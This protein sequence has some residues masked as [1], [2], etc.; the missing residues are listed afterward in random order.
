MAQHP[1]LVPQKLGHGTVG[2]P[3]NLV[4]NFYKLNISDVEI[5]HYDVEITK[6]QV[7]PQP[8]KPAFVKSVPPPSP[9]N[10]DSTGSSEKTPTAEKFIRL[11][12]PLIL[13]KVLD[14]KKDMF[15][16][17]AFVFDGYKSLYTTR[18]LVLDAVLS[19]KPGYKV[20]ITIDGR[21]KDFSFR[22]R[23]VERVAVRE[24][25]DYYA[26]KGN[27]VGERTLSAYEVA[28][29][30]I[31]GLNYENFRRSHYDIDTAEKSPK[32]RD[33]EYVFGFNSGV[34]MTE[35]GLAL[36]MHLKTSC[37]VNRQYTR[38]LD[39][40]QVVSNIR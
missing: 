24:V 1:T 18:Q 27:T 22:L 39:L 30:Y 17:V 26:G 35:V 21:P 8:E 12:S 33:V 37:I 6:F 5:F 2:R 19:G 13:K 34:A 16:D 3:V 9:D 11:F 23:L 14:E 32:T 31:F 29:N 36:N 4:A 10:S 40:V 25:L 15:K 28:L 7:N 20:T 38:L